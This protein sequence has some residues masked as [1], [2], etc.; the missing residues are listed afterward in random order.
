MRPVLDH[1]VT[2]QDNTHGDGAEVK[3]EGGCVGL[4]TTT[5]EPTESFWC[6]EEEK[7]NGGLRHRWEARENNCGHY[8]LG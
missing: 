8:L 4:L 1:L 3:V 5:T 6:A 2:M 7:N